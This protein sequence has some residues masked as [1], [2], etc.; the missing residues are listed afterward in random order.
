MKEKTNLFSK[1]VN[2]SL[3]LCSIILLIPNKFKAYPI[4]LLG[5]SA[6]LYY[7][8]NRTEQKFPFKKVGLLSLLFLLFIVSI[9]YTGDLKSAFTKLST[10]SSLLVFPVIFGLLDAS[11]YRLKTTIEKRFFLLFIFS[12]VLFIIVSF[13]YFWNQE[14]N[15][16][17]TIVHYSNLVSLRFGAFSMHPIYFSL[18]VGVAML[19]LVHTIKQEKNILNKIGYIMVFAFFGVIMAILMRK[20]PIIYLM[21]S[22]LLL[23]FFYFKIKKAVVALGVLILIIALSIQYLPKYK[24]INRFEELV[25]LNN[26]G[27]SS[28]NARIN[29]YHCAVEKIAEKPFLGY[30]IGGVQSHLDECY[31]AKKITFEDNKKSYNSHNQ[32]FGIILTIGIF[33]F[34]LYLASLYQ[35]IKVYIS[36]RSF[37]GISILA[38]FLLNFLSENLI[39]RENGALLYALLLCFFFYKKEESY[40]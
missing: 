23:M 29:I 25:N 31:T 2:L 33:G 37:L 27:K 35:I 36:K 17:E 11:D 8:K 4:I 16:S 40:S 39:E 24:N 26:T 19:M 9:A 30:G 7:I 6:I 15:F 3:L 21:L 28:T 14:F 32:Y 18:Y 5:V 34:L 13:C 1:L 22:L 38:F 20:G 12:N 10:M